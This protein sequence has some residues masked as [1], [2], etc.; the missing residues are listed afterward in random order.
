MRRGVLSSGILYFRCHNVVITLWRGEG[1]GWQRGSRST[2][3]SW[4]TEMYES[5]S[6]KFQ[7]TPGTGASDNVVPIFTHSCHLFLH[8]WPFFW[9]GSPERFRAHSARINRWKWKKGRVKWRETY[10]RHARAVGEAASKGMGVDQIRAG[11]HDNLYREIMRRN[12]IS[13]RWEEKQQHRFE[14]HCCRQL[15]SG[16][17][18]AV[19]PA[20]CWAPAANENLNQMRE[21]RWNRVQRGPRREP[22]PQTSTPTCLFRN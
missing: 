7:I 2:A 22:T 9:F 18:V 10:R 13:A 14:R 12:L 21:T 8:L 6:Q 4:H 16:W 15:Q 11:H 19:V 5:I 20:P 1:L 17:T 3:C